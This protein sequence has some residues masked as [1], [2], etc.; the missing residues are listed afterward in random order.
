MIQRFA[1]STPGGR[2]VLIADEPIGRLGTPDEIAAAV[3]W[4]CSDAASFATGHA[5]VIDGGQTV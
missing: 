3:L 2:D 4:L 5:L 1:E